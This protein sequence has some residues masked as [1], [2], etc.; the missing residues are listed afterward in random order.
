MYT[1]IPSLGAPLLGAH[2]APSWAPCAL[3]HL[4]TLSISHMVVCICQSQPPIRLP[5]RVH[6]MLLKG[7]KLWDLIFFKPWTK[8]QKEAVK[9]WALDSW[10]HVI[11]YWIK[12]QGFV[13]ITIFR[14]NVSS[15]ERNHNSD[16][17]NKAVIWSE[18]ASHQALNMS[19][20]NDCPCPF[21]KVWVSFHY[22]RSTNSWQT[23]LVTS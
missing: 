22:L 7:S 3:L 13:H 19:C 16:M 6:D 14:S 9:T 1:Y 12:R 4:P 18:N 5:T 17:L 23:V 15:L 21:S 2:R 8:L 20:L 11:F 10:N